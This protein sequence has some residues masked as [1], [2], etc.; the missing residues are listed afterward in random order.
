M[1]G[2]YHSLY[3]TDNTK[4]MNLIDVAYRHFAAAI[5]LERSLAMFVKE[6]KRQG[7][8][9]NS[10][11]RNSKSNQQQKT[12]VSKKAFYS[13]FAKN[14]NSSSNVIIVNYLSI[15]HK[16]LILIYW[17]MDDS[18]SMKGLHTLNITMKAEYWKIAKCWKVE[19]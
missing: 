5:K 4:N 1:S 10:K 18:D 16:N 2:T 9:P 15:A 3:T 8:G 11:E 12:R 7:A 17:Y 13:D 6:Y 14:L 19:I